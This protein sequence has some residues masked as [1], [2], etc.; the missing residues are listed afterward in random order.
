MLHISSGRCHLAPRLPL[1]VGTDPD[2]IGQRPQRLRSRDVCPLEG[3][4]G[5][6]AQ[7]LEGG[8][9]QAAPWGGLE[10]PRGG[11]EQPGLHA[12]VEPVVA[13]QL[14]GVAGGVPAASRFPEP[15]GHVGPA[16][17]P[18]VASDHEIHVRE[19]RLGQFDC[20]SRQGDRL[21]VIGRKGMMEL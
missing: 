4:K 18:D 12:L 8:V 6:Q 15:K 21:E 11:V 19:N 10:P 1:E 3:G 5:G 17:P 7:S 14:R 2:L 13:E 20:L 9:K 16:V